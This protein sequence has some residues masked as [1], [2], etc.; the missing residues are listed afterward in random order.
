MH[1][2]DES[3]QRLVD[4]ERRRLLTP[5]HTWNCGIYSGSTVTRDCHRGRRHDE[6]CFRPIHPSIHFGI[7]LAS[8]LLFSW[9]QEFTERCIKLLVKCQETHTNLELD[10]YTPSIFLLVHI[11]IWI[12]QPGCW[13]RGRWAIFPP[14][15]SPKCHGFRRQFYSA[16]IDTRIWMNT[17]SFLD[18]CW[19][20]PVDARESDLSSSLANDSSA[21]L[22]RIA[23]DRPAS[24]MNLTT[25]YGA[26]LM[27]TLLKRHFWGRSLLLY[28]H[29]RSP[30]N[31]WKCRFECRK[32]SCGEWLVVFSLFRAS[33]KGRGNWPRGEVREN[34]IVPCDALYITPS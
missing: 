26:R 17:L 28:A 12:H 9:N 19:F 15:R 6:N 2:K 21:S 23:N 10:V 31:L 14:V 7:P 30:W 24:P 8:F 32:Q 3:Q 22:C 5:F 29:P 13:E 33:V 18:F 27:V 34:V 4:D 25:V 11:Q 1:C 16:S 20:T